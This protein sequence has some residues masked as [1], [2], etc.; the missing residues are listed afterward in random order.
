MK[1]SDLAG[2]DLLPSGTDIDARS[3]SFRNTFSRLVKLARLADELDNQWPCTLKAEK[4][5]LLKLFAALVKAAANSMEKE[6]EQY[7]D[8][9]IK[10]V[11]GG[12]IPF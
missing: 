7:K 11:D 12:D 4:Y 3:E 9:N 2:V 5:V 10:P 8:N 6:A 1:L